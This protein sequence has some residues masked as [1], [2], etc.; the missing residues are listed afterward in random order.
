MDKFK[1]GQIVWAANMGLDKV[2]I[3]EITVDENNSLLY[4]ITSISTGASYFSNDSLL[5]EYKIQ[6][7]D[8]LKSK[9]EEKKNKY[10][11]KIKTTKD[12]LEFM[13]QEPLNGEYANYE[14]IAVVKEK[15]K[16]LL[17]I[18]L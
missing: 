11:E 18:S 13:M 3:K 1:K 10:R 17:Y 12:L 9:R 8:Y 7:Q 4:F 2:E 16:E 5:F 14:A 15:A 6:A